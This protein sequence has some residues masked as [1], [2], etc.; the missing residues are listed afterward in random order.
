MRR[1]LRAQSPGMDR[2]F[3]FGSMRPITQ[4]GLSEHQKNVQQVCSFSV[5]LFLLMTYHSRHCTKFELLYLFS[6]LGKPR[7]DRNCD[8]F[9]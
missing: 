1:T 2:N 5:L 3:G 4:G 9:G 6:G 8:Q 7:V